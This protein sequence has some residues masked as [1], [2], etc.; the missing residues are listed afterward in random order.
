MDDLQQYQRKACVI[1]DGITP[2]EHETM[3]EITKKAKNAMVKNQNFSEEEVDIKLDVIGWDQLEME[4]Y[5]Q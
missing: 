1:L 5:L 2:S 3:E 4:N